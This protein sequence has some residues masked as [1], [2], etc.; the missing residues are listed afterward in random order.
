MKAIIYTANIR[1]GGAIGGAAEL[2]DALPLYVDSEWMTWADDW[3]VHISNE[4]AAE[5]KNLQ[6]LR[7]SVSVHIGTD[8]PSLLR[9]FRRAKVS[10]G[11]RL[12]LR[13]PDYSPRRTRVE[14]LG[15]TDRSAL[16]QS[17]ARTARDRTVGRIRNSY[18]RFLV[19]RFDSYLTQTDHMAELL[20]AVSPGKSV[21]VIPNS[22]GEEFLRAARTGPS[23]I[24]ESRSTATMFYPARAYPHKNHRL[25]ERVVDVLRTEYDIALHVRCTV[26]SE[27]LEEIGVPPSEAIVPIG[28]ISRAECFAEYLASDGVLF[29]TL[30]ET[31]SATP[32]EAMALGVPVV[33]S[34]LDIIK[35][36]SGP[37]PIYFDPTDPHS[38]AEAVANLLR[39]PER[40][41]DQLAAGVTFVTTLPSHAEKTRLHLE[42]M[43]NGAI[44]QRS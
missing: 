15:F 5:M 19:R 10:D 28:E 27:E 31:S 2:L 12:V 30:N 22:P 41:A 20:R 43:R 4:V 7:Q 21:A 35:D 1:A 18:K 39:Y 37:A 26:T 14:I 29:P 23:R 42:L 8:R 9:P 24:L 36:I 33:S 34:N 17:F 3:E 13:G 44:R 11:V 16:V 38:A 40:F 32:L 6:A 25:I